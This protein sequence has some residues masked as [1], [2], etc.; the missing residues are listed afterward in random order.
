M[1]LF[2]IL[3]LVLSFI[4][5]GIYMSLIGLLWEQNE[6][7]L[8]RHLGRCL[9]HRGCRMCICCSERDVDTNEGRKGRD[10]PEVPVTVVN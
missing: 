9:A 1:G 6:F 4:N 10:F 5:G 8:M 7:I 3:I 2:I